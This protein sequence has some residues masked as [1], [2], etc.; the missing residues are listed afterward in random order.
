MQS[1]LTVCIFFDL[2]TDLEQDLFVHTW[3]NLFYQ[4]NFFLLLDNW[5]FIVEK[6]NEKQLVLQQVKTKHTIKFFVELDT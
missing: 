3:V 5:K 2:K 6:D 4:N 1:T